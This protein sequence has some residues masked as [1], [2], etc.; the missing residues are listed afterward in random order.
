MQQYKSYKYRIYPT[1]DQQVL[2]NKTFGCKRAIYNY[3]LNEQQ[4]RYA[5]KEKHLS[6]FDINKDITELKITKTWLNDVDSIALQNASADLSMSYDNFFKSITG[7]RKGPKVELP[8]FKTKNSRQS[9]RTRNVKILDDSTIKVPKLKKVKAVIHHLIPDDA[10]IKS[11]TI[12]RNPGGK[13]YASILVELNIPLKQT[14]GNH[15]GCDLGLKDLLITSDGL[16][17]KRPDGLTNIAKA[18]QLLKKKQNLG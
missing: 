4:K 6:N 18:K 13:Y 17:F 16:K 12:T 2:L 14:T 5:N 10:I 15:V 11:T 9:Y 8:K 3:Y 1:E 7:K